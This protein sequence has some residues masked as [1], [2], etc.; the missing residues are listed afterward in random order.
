MLPAVA[1]GSPAVTSGAR[2][3]EIHERD[4]SAGWVAS[5]CP[6]PCSA[7]Y[8]RRRSS[9]AG[10]GSFRSDIAGGIRRRRGGTPPRARDDRCSAPSRTPSLAPA[11]RSARAATPCRTP[12]R[13]T[14][15]TRA[16]T[17][18]PFRNCSAHKDVRTT[19]IYTHVLDRGGHGVRSPLDGPLT[20]SY[21]GLHMPHTPRLP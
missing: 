11:S 19:M 1:D 21:A 12:S 13:R 2:S 15:W 5:S 6:M 17:S 9:G 4:L 18:A 10:S 3:K 8:P 16:T 20:M 14:C 7:R